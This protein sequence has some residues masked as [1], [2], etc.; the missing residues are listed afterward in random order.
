MIPELLAICA[1]MLLGVQTIFNRKGLLTLTVASG[2][3]INLFVSTI[4]LVIYIHFSI[5]S[6][7]EFWSYHVFCFGRGNWIISWCDINI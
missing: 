5:I 3:M 4:A 7:F 2:L 1:A 6:G